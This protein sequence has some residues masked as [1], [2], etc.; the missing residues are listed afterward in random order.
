M[1]FNSIDDT[2]SI[3]CLVSKHSFAIRDT[4]TCP[5]RMAIAIQ[6]GLYNP[7]QA[8]EYSV[9]QL[10]NICQN[11]LLM[12]ISGILISLKPELQRKLEKLHQQLIQGYS[13]CQA[14]ANCSGGKVFKNCHHQV[15]NNF[16]CITIIAS[17]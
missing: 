5:K 16:V 13:E 12:F 14:V 6:S 9:Q 10:I 11:Q 7:L 1:L 8:N 4:Y 17:R 15:G 2:N 3:I